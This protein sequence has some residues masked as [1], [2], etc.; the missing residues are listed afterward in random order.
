M[1]KINSKFTCPGCG[2]KI[3]KSPLLAATDRYRHVIERA[4][5]GLAVLC[6][7]AIGRRKKITGG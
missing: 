2:K 6:P 7:E 1:S 5:S 3:P 4:R